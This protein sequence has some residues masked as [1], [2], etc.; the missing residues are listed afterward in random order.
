MHMTF[1]KKH[2][3]KFTRLKYHFSSILNTFCLFLCASYW[4]LSL[5]QRPRCSSSSCFFSSTSTVGFLQQKGWD[6]HAHA[7]AHSHSH[8]HTHMSHQFMEI[9]IVFSQCA[10]PKKSMGVICVSQRGLVYPKFHTALAHHT[11]RAL[12][13]TDPCIVHWHLHFSINSHTP[14][15]FLSESHHMSFSPNWTINKQYN[16]AHQEA[17]YRPVS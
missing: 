10:P 11:S 3:G 4:G 17:P 8:S 2:W 16:M 7:H 12:T 15:C 14:H 9:P 5:C 1:D 13:F 6:A